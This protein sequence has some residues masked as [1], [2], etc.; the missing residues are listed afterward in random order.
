MQQ[1]LALLADIK[2]QAIDIPVEMVRQCCTPQAVARLAI[3]YS[4]LNQVTVAERL[5]IRPG[6]FNIML[7]WDL[8]EARAKREAE[9]TGMP[10]RKVRKMYLDRTLENQIEMICGVEAFA[11][12]DQEF[13]AQRLLCQCDHSERKAKLLAELA[14]LEAA[15]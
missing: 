4:G 13:K 11:L 9:Q 15:E 8:H 14:E 10:R 6:D 1:S 5:D 2:R 7:N 12:W 3:Q